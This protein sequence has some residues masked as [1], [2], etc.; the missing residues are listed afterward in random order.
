MI[1]MIQTESFPVEV[2]SIGAG[3]IEGLG[4]LGCFLAP[5]LVTI[6][7]NTGTNK[8]FILSLGLLAL[9]FPLRFVPETFGK[10]KGSEESSTS[11]NDEG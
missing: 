10:S 7:I 2:E 9:I 3:S 11:L 8:M 4:Q 1:A 6:A 5:L